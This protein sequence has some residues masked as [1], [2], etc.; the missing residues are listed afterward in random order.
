MYFCA[1]IIIISDI[2]KY[3]LIFISFHQV[4]IWIRHG[5]RVPSSC[6]FV[7]TFEYVDRKSGNC[8]ADAKNIVIFAYN[9]SF[10]LTLHVA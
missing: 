3:K 6:L 4:I 8:V 9:S 7:S 2:V 10:L 1:K 5:R